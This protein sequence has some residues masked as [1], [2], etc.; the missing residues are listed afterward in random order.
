MPEHPNSSDLFAERNLWQIYRQSRAVYHNSRF[1]GV[2]LALGS[3]LLMGFAIVHFF[4]LGATNSNR[5]DFPALFSTWASAGLSWASQ[6]LGFLLAGFVVLFA[7]LR[8]HTV[9]ALQQITRPGERLYEL[10]LI[11]VTFIDVF[12]HYA[13]FMGWCLLYVVAGAKNGPF[14]LLGCWLSAMSPYL[15][16]AVTHL[17]FVAWGMWSLILIL[18]LKSFIYNLYQTLLLGMADSLRE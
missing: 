16:L 3:I 5:M 11:F 8:P 17:V 10:K 15:S 18:K 13:A 2:S 7:I 9:I 6:L 14:D 12:V 1:N 4:A